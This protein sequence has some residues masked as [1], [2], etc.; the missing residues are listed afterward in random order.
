MTEA[1]LSGN[2]ERKESQHH[3]RV[4][5]VSCDGVLVIA[6]RLGRAARSASAFSPRLP[7]GETLGRAPRGH[8]VLRAQISGPK[9]HGAG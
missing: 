4:T 1:K 8:M 3:W 9:P 5:L 7:L 2:R 6:G